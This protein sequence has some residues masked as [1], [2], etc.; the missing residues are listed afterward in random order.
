MPKD[1]S[2]FAAR[3]QD[4]INLCNFEEILN[5]RF[6]KKVRRLKYQYIYCSLTFGSSKKTYYYR[7]ED[8]NIEEGDLVIVPVGSDNHE[9]EALVV[10]V[11]Y[12]NKEDV[13]FPLNKTKFIIEKYDD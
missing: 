8:D 13:P 3:L 2:D 1:F 9:A 7:T 5:P 6:Y 10:K 4:S 12:Y 11:E